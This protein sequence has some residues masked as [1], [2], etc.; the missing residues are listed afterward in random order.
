[1]LQNLDSAHLPILLTVP[2]SPVFRPNERPFLQFSKSS[3]GW[4]C[5]FTL[6]VTVLLQNNTRLFF[7]SLLLFS[8]P[9]WHWMP[10]LR[11]G[12][13]DWSLCSFPFGKDGSG[14]LTNCSLC[15]TEATLFFLAGPVC[16]SFSAEACAICKLFA[17]LGS[18]N[19]S[20]TCL[21]LLSNSRFVLATLFSPRFFLLP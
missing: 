4:I 11:S 5:F 8:L 19:K 20:S 13:L 6:T 10:F 16:S 15:G 7:Y 17:G 18:T 2:L 3:L 9:L 21:L 14:V 12:D 1:M